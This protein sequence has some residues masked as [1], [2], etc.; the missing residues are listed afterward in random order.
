MNVRLFIRRNITSVSILVFV[1]LYSIIQY[2]Q[3][4]ILYDDKGRIRLFGIGTKKKTILP[5][6]LL[7]IILAILSYLFVLYYLTLP[8]FH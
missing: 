8:K 1:L 3:P 6:W 5:I 7:T 2:S 4:Q